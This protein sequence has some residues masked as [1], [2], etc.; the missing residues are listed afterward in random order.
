M[1]RIIPLLDILSLNHDRYPDVKSHYIMGDAV[2]V[3]YDL[4]ELI[5]ILY[6]KYTRQQALG[7]L[8]APPSTTASNRVSNTPTQPP[9]TG[10]PTPRPNQP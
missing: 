3:K 5:G 6:R 10:R 4:L 1:E 9:L 2:L 8:S 7:I